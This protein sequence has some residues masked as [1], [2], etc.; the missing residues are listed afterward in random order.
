MI[1]NVIKIL[2]TDFELEFKIS[3]ALAEVRVF[4]LGGIMKLKHQ[5]T[6]CKAIFSVWPEPTDSELKQRECHH[7]HTVGTVKKKQEIKIV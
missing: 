2:Q 3:H 7:C 5:C 1:R 4:F 6:E